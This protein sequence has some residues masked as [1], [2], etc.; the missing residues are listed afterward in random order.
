M[1]ACYKYSPIFYCLQTSFLIG[2][3]FDK[4]EEVQKVIGAYE[5]ATTRVIT[6]IEE[7]VT[8]IVELIT[9][10]G[11]TIKDV[12]DAFKHVKLQ[13]EKMPIDHS[14]AVMLLLAEV[15]T[16]LGQLPSL[17]Q[18]KPKRGKKKKKKR[19]AA[20]VPPYVPPEV[21][22]AEETQA[23]EPTS[24]KTLTPQEQLEQNY[25]LGLVV[26]R[27]AR[28]K[29]QRAERLQLEQDQRAEAER[30]QLEQEERATIKAKKK[31]DK[32]ERRK[33]EKKEK[34]R[35]KKS[36]VAD[37]SDS[38]DSDYAPTDDGEKIGDQSMFYSYARLVEQ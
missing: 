20:D 29:N 13:L 21:S 5:T 7:E 26:A 6:H 16:A 9:E 3:I 10:E 34:K 32:K 22:L 36:V 17:P 37:L 25:V 28:E 27:Q 12:L 30:L 2:K 18:A 24:Q 1:S 33:K 11:S 31:K 38:H 14:P 8:R 19:K 15:K 4:V 35:K 23:A